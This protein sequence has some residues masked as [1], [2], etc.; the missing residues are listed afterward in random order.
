MDILLELNLDPRH[1]RVKTHAASKDKGQSQIRNGKVQTVVNYTI[2]LRK[3]AKLVAEAVV[4][5][6]KQTFADKASRKVFLQN[7]WQRVRGVDVKAVGVVANGVAARRPKVK[8]KMQRVINRIVQKKQEPSKLK[9]YVEQTAQRQ[10]KGWHNYTPQSSGG[11][12]SSPKRAT[13]LSLTTV[14][15]PKGATDSSVSDGVISKQEQ[16]PAAAA[17]K[18]AQPGQDNPSATDQAEVK[19]DDVN[20]DEADDL[21]KELDG[22]IGKQKAEPKAAKPFP[23]QEPESSFAHAANS[24]IRQQQMINHLRRI[25]ATRA[26]KKRNRSSLQ[27][28]STRKPPGTNSF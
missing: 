6:L 16:N 14:S 20:A 18:P 9:Q 28:V 23:K 25:S 10:I 13:G 7:F 21:T 2:K 1:I 22:I 17:A 5:R 11:L 15:S 3:D 27:F 8:F 19:N 26:L 4:L 12:K 24:S